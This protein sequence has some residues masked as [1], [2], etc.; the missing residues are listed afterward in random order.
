MLFIFNRA[1]VILLP[2]YRKQFTASAKRKKPVNIHFYELLI[3][4]NIW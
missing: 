3:F 1:T 4:K 2:P